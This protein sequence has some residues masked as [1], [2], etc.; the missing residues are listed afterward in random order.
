MNKENI[1]KLISMMVGLTNS[2][3]MDYSEI[4]HDETVSDCLMDFYFSMLNN[5]QEIIDKHY[6]KLE[7]KYNK[8]NE[9][10]KELA[11]G[12]IAKILNIEYKPKVKKKER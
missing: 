9:E 1:Y 4:I 10:Q 6:N 7:E 11:K 12:E 8:L 3:Y 2:E 5:E